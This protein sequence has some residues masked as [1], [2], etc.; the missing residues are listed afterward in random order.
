MERL[1]SFADLLELQEV[2]AKIDQLIEDRRSLP[3]LAQ[4]AQADQAAQ[5]AVAA[6]DEATHLLRSLDRDLARLDHE[7]QVSEQK[8][9]EQE[10]RLFAGGMNARETQN[11]RDE[12]ESLR[13]RISTIEDDLLDL[14]EQRDSRQERQQALEEEAD[15]ARE[16]EQRL[17]GLVNE[18][19][20]TIDASL[21][22]YRERRGGIV[23]LVAPD[24]LAMYRR[25]RERRGGIVVGAVS[26]RVCG[27]CHLAMSM[28]E[29]EE[30]REDPI[31]QCIHCAAILVL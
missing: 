15:S 16:A 31:P 24:L 17:A 1:T 13:R 2:D 11:M 9:G 14:L 5:V 28:G 19:L 30:I 8:L 6:H 3:E 25:L 21:I 26:G 7:L 22:R 29:Y 27:A 20:G 4:H 23:G 18:A 10:R 12:V